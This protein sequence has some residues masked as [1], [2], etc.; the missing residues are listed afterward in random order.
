MFHSIAITSF[1]NLKEIDAQT[2]FT[3]SQMLSTFCY[4]DN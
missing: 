3:S 2:Y 4:I 1:E